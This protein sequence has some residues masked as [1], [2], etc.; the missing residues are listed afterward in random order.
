MNPVLEKAIYA[1]ATTWTLVKCIQEFHVGSN[2][3]GVA[4]LLS[5]ISNVLIYWEEYYE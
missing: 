4:Y 1:V 5:V 2:V 3:K